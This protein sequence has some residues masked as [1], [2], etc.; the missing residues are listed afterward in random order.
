MV[1]PLEVPQPLALAKCVLVHPNGHRVSQAVDVD[2]QVQM[3][4]GQQPESA[5]KG[6]ANSGYKMMGRELKRWFRG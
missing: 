1:F 2:T 3:R 6:P 4:G 5:G